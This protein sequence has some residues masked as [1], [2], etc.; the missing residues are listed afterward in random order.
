MISVAP[1][2]T[3]SWACDPKLVSYVLEQAERHISTDIANKRSCTILPG[4]HCILLIY[5]TQGPRA[6]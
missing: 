3:T 5:V 1:I 2:A 6:G 4:P